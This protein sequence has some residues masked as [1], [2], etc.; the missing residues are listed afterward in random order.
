MEPLSTA[1]DKSPSSTVVDE[2]R[3]VFGADETT[4][5]HSNVDDTAISALSIN[6]PDLPPNES[7]TFCEEASID[8]AAEHLDT[9]ASVDSYEPTLEDHEELNDF[10]EKVR[11]L[12]AQE[13]DSVCDFDDCA[14]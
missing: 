7:A 3:S 12:M 14:G 13:T 10:L 2:S 4:S 6:C 9:P 1:D 5:H 11:V 8:D